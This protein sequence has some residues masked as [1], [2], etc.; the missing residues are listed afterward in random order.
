MPTGEDDRKV[1]EKVELLSLKERRK[2]KRSIKMKKP[3]FTS[4]YR[5]L[6]RS[7]LFSVLLS[8]SQPSDQSNASC[9]SRLS[10]FGL[11]LLF[12]IFAVFFL[13]FAPCFFAV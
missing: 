9:A 13:L 4:I 2:R 5:D 1:R 6:N 11:G 10:D 8:H 7:G 3:D 12:S